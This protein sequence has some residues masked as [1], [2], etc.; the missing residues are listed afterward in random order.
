MFSGIITHL[1]QVEKAEKEGSALRLTV[2]TGMPDLELGESVA[3]NGVCLTVE[4]YGKSGQ[5]TFFL[6]PETLD[7]SA[8]GKLKPQTKVNLERALQLNARLSGHIVQ[9]HVDGKATL[10][11]AQKIGE[12]HEITLFVPQE[13][14]RYFVPKGSVCLD[15]VSLTI[16]DIKDSQTY[17]GELGFT[18]S[19]MLV[20]HTW[21][22]TRFH[23]LNISDEMNIE[24]DIIGRYV[25]TM[26]RFPPPVPTVS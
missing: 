25:E 17:Q 10:L 14:R 9:G 12:A 3:V 8:L 15:G 7:C 24:T 20:P 5:A 18:L 26:L 1:G 19:I 11:R 22:H 23:S 2:Q 13:I 16:N 21:E 4:T 6:S